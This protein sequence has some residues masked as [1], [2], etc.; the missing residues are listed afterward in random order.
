MPK[1][2]RTGLWKKAEVEASNEASLSPKSPK[3]KVEIPFSK[4]RYINEGNNTELIQENKKKAVEFLKKEKEEKKKKD[5]E[6]L[7]LIEKKRRYTEQVRR[8]N[9]EKLKKSKRRNNSVE[10]GDSDMKAVKHATSVR[11]K[12][13]EIKGKSYGMAR[14]YA[15]NR[16]K[17]THHSEV[18]AED[19][20][21]ERKDYIQTLSVEDEVRNHTIEQNDLERANEVRREQ[22]VRASYKVAINVDLISKMN[23]NHKEVISFHHIDNSEQKNSIDEDDGKYVK[24][25][26]L[27][28]GEKYSHKCSDNKLSVHST[29][30]ESKKTNRCHSSQKKKSIKVAKEILECKKDLAKMQKLS[31]IRKRR[32]VEES[33]IDRDIERRKQNLELL[34][35]MLKKRNQHFKKKKRNQEKLLKKD[36]DNFEKSLGVSFTKK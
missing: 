32:V 9:K 15:R 1:P 33:E 12:S 35:E 30:K 5:I 11:A 14:R 27:N 7:N 8:Q 3:P 23:K 22:P 4:N 19:S 36:L 13:E 2:K 29:E 20:E 21:R 17:Q 25:P 34:N 18:K 24:T 31:E 16:A 10:G 28:M 26:E 6:R